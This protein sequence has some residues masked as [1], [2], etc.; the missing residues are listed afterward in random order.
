MQKRDPTPG[1]IM[2]ISLHESI[3][4]WRIGHLGD[5]SRAERSTMQASY[6]LVNHLWY[7][8]KGKDVTNSAKPDWKQSSSHQRVTLLHSGGDINAASDYGW[9]PLACTT[10]RGHIDV[11]EL[12]IDSG[13]DSSIA[14]NNGDTPLHLASFRGYLDIA[15]LLLGNDTVTSVADHNGSKSLSLSLSE[16]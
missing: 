15:K 9:T 11:V 1:E 13:A 5:G 8:C 7:S 4:R 14:G 6:A 10:W 16:G 12:L 3:C 2:N